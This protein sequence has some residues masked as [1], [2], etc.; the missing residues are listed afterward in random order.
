ME[1]NDAIVANCRRER[2]ACFDHTLHLTV[3]DGVKESQCV[4]AAVAKCCKISSMLHTSSLFHHAFEEKFGK[5]KSIPAAVVTR[6]NSTLRQIKSIISLDAKQL[7]DLL[8][9][10]NHRNLVFTTRERAQLIELV[11][12][13]DPFLEA[14]MLT[15]GRQNSY[16][17]FCAAMHCVPGS[18]LEGRTAIT[19]SENMPTCLQS[20]AEIHTSAFCWTAHQNSAAK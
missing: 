16:T 11:D 8:E 13:L 10:Q 15:E 12:I 1:V 7:S 6:W 20:P 5:K 3:A 9:A 18:Q 19:A 4:S 2:L 14:T 17:E